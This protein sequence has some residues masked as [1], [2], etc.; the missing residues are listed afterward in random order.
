VLTGPPI[1]TPAAADAD[2]D[3][4][5]AAVVAAV[6]RRRSRGNGERM[7]DV[8]R[9]EGEFDSVYDVGDDTAP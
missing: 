8:A 9:V 4:A 3:A 1:A 6:K 7:T 2:S 5:A